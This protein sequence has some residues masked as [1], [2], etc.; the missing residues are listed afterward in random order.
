[1]GFDPGPG[2]SGGD[3]LRGAAARDGEPDATPGGCTLCDLPVGDDPVTASDVDGAFCCR[4]CLSVARR[5]ETVDAAGRGNATD[6]PAGGT[7]GE[8]DGPA[9]A[10]DVLDAGPST[11]S[12][13]G[14]DAFLA[15]DGMHCATCETFLEANAV[16]REGVRAADASYAADLVRVVYDPETVAPGELPDAVGGLG[17]DAR[18]VED[19]GD[20]DPGGTEEETVGRLLVGGFFGMLVMLWYVLFLYPTYLGVGPDAV[21]IDLNGVAGRYLLGNVWVMSTIV[22][23]YTG[24]PILRGAY[25][26]LRARE[27]NM[28]L[29][30][31]LAAS[32]AYAYST[33]AL[34]LGHTE[35][36]FDVTVVV[37]LAVSV[38][39]YYERR[40]K[41]RATG[42]LADLATERVETA[43]RRTPGGTETVDLSAVEAGDELVVR[44]GERVPL[45]GEVI[46]GTGAVDEALVT[47]ESLPVRKEAGDEV[48]GGAELRE[49]ALVVAVDDA[50]RNTL[51]RITRRLWAVQSGRRGAQR[52]ADRIAVVF[53]PLV[54]ALAVLTTGAH[55]ML[56][57]TPTGALLTGLAVLVVSCPCALGLATPLSVAAGVRA[58]LERGIV[59]TDASL[60][61]RAT[62]ADVVGFDKTGTLTT[63]DLEL[64]D[65]PDA[66]LLADAAALEQ[67]ADHPLA[68][69]V[70]EAAP[71]G[72][73]GTGVGP[74]VGEAATDGGVA[75]D[76]ALD[77]ELSDGAAPREEPTDGA[78]T[79][80][81]EAAAE[82]ET[83]APQADGR[84]S[85]F[86][87][88]PGRGVSG[89]VAGREVVVGRP[90][91]F[92]GRGWDVPDDL[93]ERFEAAREDAKVAALVGREGAAEGLIAAADAPRPEWERVVE[94]LSDGRDVVVITGDDG[95]A[96]RPFREHPAVDDVFAGVPPEGK[97]ALVER[98]RS[99]GTVAM[100]GDGSNDAPALA[101]ADVGIALADGTAL[102]VEAADAVV[103]SG[104][105]GAVPT[106]FDVTRA[107]RRR[108]RENVGW[109][110][111]Y[112]VVAVPAAAV[113]LLSPLVAAVAMAA[114]SLLVVGNASRSLLE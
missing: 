34:A 42:R 74:A 29:L 104:D 63:G 87:N 107:T 60:F 112:N 3:D 14:E 43:R 88:H 80:S 64:V 38:G 99:R 108:V 83:A 16:D 23:A 113:G 4:G 24:Y 31:A 86:E 33:L 7:A 6:D 48:V 27:P 109:A 89:T 59:V 18:P 69:A 13:D 5:L 20:A 81:G 78:G 57:A 41:N 85:D 25:V 101:A 56:G 40:I 17:Y 32:T 51:D 58:A 75:D 106:V 66:D 91:L 103:T 94:A 77:E 73:G 36:Y 79:A 102:A 10:A 90:A 70:V 15:V 100:V 114:S 46:E 50:E 30:V 97:G 110:F 53:V 65:S 52:L 82:P 47:G 49:G 111:L 96:A 22:L 8:T 105:L 84:V 93:R 72:S 71:G 19:A 9:D 61:E 44:A 76:A 62:E 98:L 12:V 11:S 35:L 26:S 37:V 2:E 67:L 54:F 68:P 1:M 92:E 28:D 21:F 95:A 39:G 45:D 55:L